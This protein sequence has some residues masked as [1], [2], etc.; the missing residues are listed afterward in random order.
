MVEYS[1]AIIE[2]HESVTVPKKSTHFNIHND[3]IVQFYRLSELGVLLYYSCFSE[4][5]KSNNKEMILF[6][7]NN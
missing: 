1:D 6:K 4:W 2:I 3:K 7:I 5:S